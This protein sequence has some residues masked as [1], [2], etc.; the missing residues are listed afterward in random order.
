MKSLL[1][2]YAL[3]GTLY[4]LAMVDCQCVDKN[5]CGLNAVC[6]DDG[7]GGHTC[8]CL[9]GYVRQDGSQTHCVIG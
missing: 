8:H 4:P 7:K 2:M 1:L 5:D 3:V 9:F 6:R